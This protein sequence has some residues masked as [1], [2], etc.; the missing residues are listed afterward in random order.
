MWILVVLGTVGALYLI[1]RLGV[2]K[3]EEPEPKPKP[4]KPI[5]P[6]PPPKP[7][8]PK[9]DTS[10][11]R[12]ILFN[13]IDEMNEDFPLEK[14]LDHVK[15]HCN[16]LR[17]F[18]ITSGRTIPPT[19]GSYKDQIRR[20]AIESLQRGIRPRITIFD[21]CF[22]RLV[23]VTYPFKDRAGSYKEMLEKENFKRIF[24]AHTE[25]LVDCL[26]F[27]YDGQPILPLVEWECTNESR[28]VSGG[29]PRP[30]NLVGVIS[31]TLQDNG[32]PAHKIFDSSTHNWA[33][34]LLGL[35]RKES[36]GTPW[37]DWVK[38]EYPWT[39]KTFSFHGMPKNLHEQPIYHDKRG[40]EALE[41]FFA[42]YK[43][44]A[45]IEL[46]ADGV[47]PRPSV[48]NM[49][50]LAKSMRAV[51]KRCHF[52]GIEWLDYISREWRQDPGLVTHDDIIK[53]LEAIKEFVK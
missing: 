25:F 9:I 10:K 14:W 30:R 4:P 33:K 36:D 3:H 11:G 37:C 47:K 50:F 7:K 34:I 24:I 48:E 1:W 19:A 31:K 35:H 16:T 49:R 13:G 2:P 22:P 5:S 29:R 17:F 26:N 42:G 41:K 6:V 38:F 43:I 44:S 8:L 23:W 21:D 28:P 12:V 40:L 52:T 46:S 18:S 45:G 15:E 32:V 20:V 39:V 27:S 53:Y 51:K